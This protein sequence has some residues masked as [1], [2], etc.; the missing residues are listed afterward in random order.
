MFNFLKNKSSVFLIL[1]ITFS[2]SLSSFSN[3]FTAL[4]GALFNAPKVGAQSQSSSS[5]VSSSLSSYILGKGD[6]TI[7]TQGGPIEYF[8]S[9]SIVNN[10]YY[11]SNNGQTY[12][13][14]GGSYQNDIIGNY[15]YGAIV[16][17][18]CNIYWSGYF[19]PTGPISYYPPVSSI[20]SSSYV[21]NPSSIGYSSSTQEPVYT[22]SSVQGPATVSLIQLETTSSIVPPSSV[23]SSAVTVSS[24][25]N[26]PTSY[27][28]IPNCPVV[29][30]SSKNYY[31]GGQISLQN[32]SPYTSN[33]LSANIN[34]PMGVT[35]YSLEKGYNFYQNGNNLNISFPDVGPYGEISTYYY[36]NYN[37]ADYN[38]NVVINCNQ[39][40]NLPASSLVSSSSVLNV[41]S[42]TQSSS[43]QNQNQGSGDERCE[44][45]IQQQDCQKECRNHNRDARNRNNESQQER[46]NRQRRER[47]CNTQSSQ[48][49]VIAINSAS[50]VSLPECPTGPFPDENSCYCPSPKTITFDPTPVGGNDHSHYCKLV[51]VTPEGLPI[52]DGEIVINVNTCI[53]P[54]PRQFID[55]SAEVDH[56]HICKILEVVSSSSI[57]L[58]IPEVVSSSSNST[59]EVI[60]SSSRAISST[61]P[62]FCESPNLVLSNDQ[63][64]CICP[65][66]GELIYIE[67]DANG[68]EESICRA[69]PPQVVTS[70]SSLSATS[71]SNPASS[72]LSSLSS[73]EGF[74]GCES[75][76][77]IVSPDGK[78]CICPKAGDLIWIIKNSNGIEESICAAIDPRLTSDSSSSSISNSSSSSVVSSSSVEVAPLIPSGSGG[79][80]ITIGGIGGS[81]ENIPST[82]ASSQ[83]A[84]LAVRL[85][86]QLAARDIPVNCEDSLKVNGVCPT[87]GTLDARQVP[88]TSTDMFSIEDPYTCGGSL[89]GKVMN[90][91]S[92][93]VKYEF[94]KNGSSTP[95]FSYDVPVNANG[96]FELAIDYNNIP[97]D[98]Y[99]IIF[100]TKN[101][102]GMVVSNSIEEY[103]TSNCTGVNAL[104]Y[105]ANKTVRTGGQG[106]T[107]ILMVVFGLLALVGVVRFTLTKPSVN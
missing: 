78:L 88:A 97:E 21:Y 67:K 11:N 99:K 44:E 84:N 74:K 63:K 53:C 12:Y 60:A 37:G 51:E 54:E 85:S 16:G 103:V 18:F 82:Q 55:T 34:L 40:T 35:V 91:N 83:N 80:I 4:P 2:I 50:V 96:A 77:L 66:A 76:N 104:K 89:K 20:S 28:I 95:A 27:S 42:A 7:R 56:Y 72:S 46:N 23:S 57:S 33:N 62:P 73:T 10:Y 49:S 106:L 48:S 98:T 68:K 105:Y 31:V 75:P 45:N 94:F 101:N 58:S 41:A 24:I 100:S 9:S 13:C 26:N 39:I 6:A 1:V 30:N 29:V 64:L 59:V 22:S 81:G 15:F 61:K 14:T 38:S 36:T 79:G 3:S 25:A 69:T 32:N 17:A 43:S 52:C 87:Q 102:S 90:T 65:K 70:S 86:G 8:S 19:Y 47:N 92:K 107:P 5:I 71:S 93:T